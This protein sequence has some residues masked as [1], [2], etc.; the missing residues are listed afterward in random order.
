[1]NL[2]D[3]LGIKNDATQDEIK[4][5][6][7]RLVI[8]YH[9]DKCSLPNS[10]EKFQEVQAAYE[11]LS[12]LDKR[13]DY[14][15]MS[16]EQKNRVYD[17]LKEYFMNIKPE[18]SYIYKSIIEGLY[19]N[20]ESAFES[21]VNTFNIRNIFTR[22]A[23]I[24]ITK[25]DVIEISKNEYDLKLTFKERYNEFFKYVHVTYGSLNN[26]YIVPLYEDEFNID[27]PNLGKV[28]IKI[29]FDEPKNYQIIDKFNLLYVKNVSLSQYIYGSTIKLYDANGDLIVFEFS[30][31]LE[32]K[33]VFMIP[34]KGLPK[35]SNKQRGDL[36]VYLT[37]EGINS[38]N[39]NDLTKNY[40]KVVEDTLKL[41]F[42]AIE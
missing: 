7:R 31:C 30:S 23:N 24:I 2:Y 33:P 5:S 37:V 22:I 32:K 40:C 6:Y 16:S 10:K 1:M 29:S 34:N 18:H 3:V 25:N 8:K 21:D 42:P 13:K 19:S 38:I 20:E 4:K 12:D 17:L 27:D 41:M 36:Y 26:E 28:T 39:D 11:I 14:D 9:P 15:N 35:A